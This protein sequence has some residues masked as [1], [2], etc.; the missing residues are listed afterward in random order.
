MSVNTNQLNELCKTIDNVE[1]RRMIVEL[2]KDVDTAFTGNNE[3]NETVELHISDE[4]MI[5][6]TYQNNGWLRVNYY[7]KD[8]AAEG[9][10]FEGRWN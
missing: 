2:Y 4:G 3:H 10:T 6:K 7:D 8:G 9:E 1:T 5:I